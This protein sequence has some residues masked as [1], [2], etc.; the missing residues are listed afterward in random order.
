MGRKLDVQIML[1][2]FFFVLFDSWKVFPHLS[3]SKHQAKQTLRAGGFEVKGVQKLLEV[4]V[5]L[6]C[7]VMSNTTHLSGRAGRR[8]A[9]LLQS[10][11]EKK[12]WMPSYCG[13]QLSLFKPN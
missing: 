1:L 2:F 6:S 8:S 4:V 12:W 13:G 7:R 5:V 11:P 3:M 9:K 10:T